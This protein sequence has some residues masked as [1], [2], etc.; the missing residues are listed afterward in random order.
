M[1]NEEDLSGL[2]IREVGR[3]LN[4]ESPVHPTTVKYHWLKLFEANEVRYLY[5]GGEA[6]KEVVVNDSALGNGSIVSIPVYGMA[7]CGPATKVAEQN[8]LGS[9]SIS[10]NLLKTKHYDNL[11]AL[12]ASGMSMNKASING[13]PVC[14]GDYVIID[15]SKISPRNNE[16]VVAIVNGLANIK[17]FKK[18]DGRIVLLSDSTERFD[19]IFIHPED[20][21]DNLIGGTVIQVV[22]K[23]TS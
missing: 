19:P 23:P 10:S 18:E 7:D 2:S 9:L 17:R 3:R 5:K 6:A 8:D 12:K 14:D 13:E 21:S 16:C 4:C 15:R 22:K 1:I 20:Q 11:Y